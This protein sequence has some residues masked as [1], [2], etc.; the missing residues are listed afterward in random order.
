MHFFLGTERNVGHGYG[1]KEKSKQKLLKHRHFFLPRKFTQEV[2]DDN[3]DALYSQNVAHLT[4]YLEM[5]HSE[6]IV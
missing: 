1:K 6:K 5:F 4:K 3:D 2:W